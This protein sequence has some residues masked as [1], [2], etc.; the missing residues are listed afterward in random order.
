MW[1]D[2]LVLAKMTLLMPSVFDHQ[3]NIILLREL[4]ASNNVI[5]SAYFNGVLNIV[6]LITGRVSWS[7][8]I[9]AR[10]LL[11][12]SHEARRVVEANQD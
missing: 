1:L 5:C 9:A 12:C 7:K 11:V 8:R 3:T 10:I 2:L 4:Y 6:S